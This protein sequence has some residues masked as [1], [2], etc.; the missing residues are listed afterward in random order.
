M[1]QVDDAD[2]SL[3]FIGEDVIG[4]TPRNED[5]R[6]RLGSS[7]DVLGERKQLDYTIDQRAKWLEETIE[8][9]LTNRKDVAQEV[10]VAEPLYRWANWAISEQSDKYRKID[11]R[12]VHFT[13]SVPADGERKISYK[14]RYTW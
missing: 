9:T 13:V 1:S 8:I 14:V 10:T 6:I 3:E 5:V 12:L 2:G 7:F 11:A 4:H